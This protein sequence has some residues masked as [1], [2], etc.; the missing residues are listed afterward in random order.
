MYTLE[1]LPK[2]S[3]SIGF[4][5]SGFQRDIIFFKFKKNLFI[6]S[7]NLSLKAS[8]GELKIEISG[9]V[10]KNSGI[11][12]CVAN[13]PLSLLTWFSDGSDT[14]AVFPENGGF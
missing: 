5:K 1:E 7:I 10:V 2:C 4:L 3:L 9:V 14:L 6:I 13:P 11:F 12:P 8:K